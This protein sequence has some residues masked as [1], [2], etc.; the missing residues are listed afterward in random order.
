MLHL[1]ARSRMISAA[2][3]ILGLGLSLLFPMPAVMAAQT[4]NLEITNLDLQIWPEYDDP[5]VLAIFSGTLKNVSDQSYSGLV[6]FNVPKNIEVQMACEIVNGDQHSCQRF[7]V[8]DK[9]GVQVLS[10]RTTKP[11]PP[12]GEYPFWLEYYY[13]PLQGSPDKTME[14]NYTPFY[15]TKA[16]SLTVKQPLTATNFKI[17]PQTST[18]AKDSE[19]F[20]NHNL[21]FNNVEPANPILLNISY[22]KTQAQPSVQPPQQNGG[23][24]SGTQ[25]DDGSGWKSK[26]V[27]APVILLP[28]ALIGYVAYSLLSAKKQQ[29]SGRVN[30][31]RSKYKV[32]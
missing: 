22:T 26:M 9:D 12:G 13:N 32:K 25:P 27:I 10:W 6:S 19:G 24:N 17:T 20:T 31:N 5:R 8:E 28:A 1:L 30:R 18:V 21:I 11:I 29:R 4:E 14:L 23:V 15:K 16:L 3:L 7:Q 2:F